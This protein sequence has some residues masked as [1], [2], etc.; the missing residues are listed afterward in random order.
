MDIKEAVEIFEKY[1]IKT[2][3]DNNNM[4][5]ISH[6]CQPKEK[7][8]SELGINEDECANLDAE[9]ILQVGDR[10]HSNNLKYLI[11]YIRSNL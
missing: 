3:V 8:F 4:I 9:S 10:Y 7:T 2:S 1:G 11:R 6:Y 5:T